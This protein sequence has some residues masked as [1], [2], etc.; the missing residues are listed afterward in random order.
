MSDLKEP[1]LRAGVVDGEVDGVAD[2]H[3]GDVH[4][5]AVLP[6][7]LGKRRHIPLVLHALALAGLLLA[8]ARRPA[9]S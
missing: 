2:R 6:R 8:L 4:V 1:T 9:T 7:R 3:V 5:A